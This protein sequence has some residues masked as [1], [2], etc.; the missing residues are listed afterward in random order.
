[1]KRALSSIGFIALVLAT[2]APAAGQP[3]QEWREA[4][5]ADN[6]RRHE[7]APFQTLR[8]QGAVEPDFVRPNTGPS[9][10]ELAAAR[11]NRA[12]D[13]F[14]SAYTAEGRPR[15]AI[16]WNRELTGDVRE[17]NVVGGTL[18]PESHTETVVRRGPDGRE[19]W[20]RTE[21]DGGSFENVHTGPAPDGA[22]GALDEEWLWRF[23][24][25]FTQPFLD[26]RCK[27][28][29]RSTIMRLR[30]AQTSRTG[31]DY[32]GLA[33]KKVEIDA[34][35]EHAD[36]LVEVLV[37]GS[38]PGDYKLRANVK[39]VRTGRILAVVRGKPT[40]GSSHIGIGANGFERVTIAPSESDSVEGFAEEVMSALVGAWS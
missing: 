12:R 15:I 29:D 31:I 7:A 21:R 38:G 13:D 9:D 36:V 3:A 18:K 14:R 37:S 32:A 34:L 20:A 8:E 16:L 5:P 6:A 2:A 1:M 39:E 23:E 22:R 11:T 19:E 10:A 30:A 35:A 17:W 24:E 28:I 25:A 26:T 27:V 33:A 40:P 4:S